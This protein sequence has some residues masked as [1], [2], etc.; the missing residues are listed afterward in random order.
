[1]KNPYCSICESYSELKTGQ[2]IYPHRPD[3]KGISIYECQKCKRRV[4]CHKGTQK[5]LGT[6]STEEE[7]KARMMAHASFDPLWK[8]GG[9]KRTQAYKMLSEFLGL[10]LSK[11]HIGMF[12]VATC[13]KVIQ[14]TK[15]IA[16]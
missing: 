12:D 1:M 4:G 14:F 13:R 3:L 2:D 11:T 16:P 10:E 8:K 5:P 9:L 15:E 6:L 7:R